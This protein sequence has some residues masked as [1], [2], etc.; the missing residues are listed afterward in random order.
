MP[1][2]SIRTDT[3]EPGVC[4]YFHAAIELIGMRWNGLILQLLAERPLRYAD[5]KAHIREVSPTMLSQRLRE[6]EA[7]RLLVREVEPGPPVHV[8]YR[9]TEAGDALQPIL[10][11]ITAW[12]HDWLPA[13][14]AAQ[15]DVHR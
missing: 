3:A 4:P 10:R 15:P 1:T 11:A 2:G 7:A 9:L 8:R 14:G 12:G 13:T 5:V 6:L